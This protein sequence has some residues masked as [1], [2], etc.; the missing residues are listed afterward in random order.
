MPSDFCDLKTWTHHSY[1]AYIVLQSQTIKEKQPTSGVINAE[2][3]NKAWK[4]QGMERPLWL[5]H[6]LLACPDRKGTE[7]NPL[8]PYRS[9]KT[10][11]VTEAS[12]GSVLGEEESGESKEECV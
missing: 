5:E 2:E 1:R 6:R 4:G 7:D 10:T 8:V 12:R 9:V 3:K 11:L